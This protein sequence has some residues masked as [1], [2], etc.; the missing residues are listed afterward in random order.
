MRV[1][2][3][4]VFAIFAAAATLTNLV[5][6]Q[7]S[8]SASIHRCVHG[9]HINVSSIVNLKLLATFVQLQK[10]CPKQEMVPPK[11]LAWGVTLQNLIAFRA[12]NH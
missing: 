1:K 7:L 6:G 2:F 3:R 10:S 12:V 8:S 9:K 5:D 11:N 4:V